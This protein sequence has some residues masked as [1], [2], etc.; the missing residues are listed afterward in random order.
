LEPPLQLSQEVVTASAEAIKTD[1][2]H[3]FWSAQPSRELIE[4]I[5]DFGQTT[6]ILVRE[7]DNGLELIAGHARL[8]VLRDKGL[9]VL[10]RMVIDA[11]DTDLGLLHLADNTQRALDDGMRL[12]AMNYFRPLMNND[13]LRQEILPRLGVKPKSKDGRLLLSWLNLPDEWQTLLKKGRIPL[14]IGTVLE[15]LADDDRRALLVLFKD[16]S[17]SRSNAVNCITWLYE[18]SK[19]QACPVSEIMDK[20]GLPDILSQ[21]LSPKDT[22]SRICE[23]SQVARYPELSALRHMFNDTA[24]ELSAGTSWRITQPNNFETGG[25]ELTVQVKT[26]EQLQKALADLETMAD[27]PLWN[28]IWDK[29]N[30]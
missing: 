11:T 20:A 21:G 28:S 5:E 23:A 14:A 18:A 27:S 3:L 22:I 26:P 15:R 30:D 6:P 2:K 25:A 13:Q 1:G 9:P 12:T 8:C 19:M 7:T 29:T 17:W 4:S 24:R 16:F 10:A